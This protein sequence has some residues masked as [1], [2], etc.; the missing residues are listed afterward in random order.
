VVLLS[1]FQQY[2]TKI[3]LS[4]Q[5]WVKIGYKSVLILPLISSEDKIIGVITLFSPEAG[6]FMDEQI[7]L[8]II[9]A[10]YTSSVLEN[11]IFVDML[12]QKVKEK[13][14]ALLQSESR[15]KR[16]IESVT[17]YIYTVKVEDG[18][19]VSTTH[20]PACVRITGYT[21]EDYEADPFLWYRMIHKEDRQAVM[22]HT[23]KLLS[24]YESSY[25]EH[26]IIHK[27]GSIRWISNTQVANRD[28]QGHLIA[29]DGMIADITERKRME[30]LLLRQSKE[31]RAFAESTSLL[32]T[33]PSTK[34]LYEA[35]CELVIRIFEMKIVWIGIISEGSLDVSPVAQA[36]SPEDDLILTKFIW[37]T[38]MTEMGPA[39]KAITTRSLQ[40]VNDIA[41][42]TQ[43]PLWRDAA[44]SLGCYSSVIL[45]LISSE[46]GVI[47]LLNLY[48]SEPLFFEHE[49]LGVF[50]VFANHASSVIENRWLIEGL[51]K[52]VRVR[53]KE[54]EYMNFELAAL[55]KELELRRQEAE[56]AKIQA[57]TANKAKSD[58][59]ANM[60]HELRTPLNSIIGFSDLMYDGVSGPITDEQKEYLND[61]KES[62]LHLLA[63]INDILDLSK[64]EAGKMELEPSKFNLK[65][66]IERSIIMFKE[67]A[68]EHK[69]EITAEVEEGLDNIIADEMKIKQAIFN[70]LSNAMKFMPD[71]GSVRVV[72]RRVT[73]QDT[74]YKMQDEN[75]VHH[76]SCIMN[77]GKDF[78]EISV[79]DTGIGISPEDQ[80]KL[81]QPFKQ[82]ES[83][84]SKKYAGTGL[85]LSLCK[86]FIE[87][88]GGRIWVE[89]EQGQGSRFAFVIPVRQCRAD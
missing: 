50:H 6:S 27:D 67:K 8:F 29:Y 72:A 78:V 46:G 66:L 31:L 87:L 1:N 5:Y 88:H 55:N 10:G 35:I 63:L 40:V 83:V 19:P 85:G 86:R 41:S 45:P 34:N 17:D 74:G 70:L 71:G 68:M 15:Y 79:T 18:R 58:F 11:I 82:L 33:L 30:E 26:R 43:Y 4:E 84:L 65:K 25:L 9:F 77:H 37:D 14:K 64:V 12:E 3:I 52:K 13:T 61:I 56:D 76:A 59:L 28:A 7:E 57:E 20:G 24:G 44:M 53:T 49:R 73:M 48:S 32:I 2:T 89:S 51:E 47:G 42:D 38:N 81:F 23:L 60:S 39:S 16:L 75:I 54:L 69:S 22:E 62:G 80:K 36:G 21:S